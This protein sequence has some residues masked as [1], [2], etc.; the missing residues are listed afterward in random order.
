M[1]TAAI[2]IFL[3]FFTLFV[4]GTLLKNN[5]IV[6]IG[7][8]IGFV[9]LAWILFFLR[10]PVQLVRTTIT[11]LVSLWGIRLFYHILKPQPR[12]AGRLSLCG[13]P[14]GLG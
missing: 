13:V 10:L 2:V 5:S 1:T 3:Y 4:V 12:K 11:L 8:G 14:Q 7:W 9:I 6:D